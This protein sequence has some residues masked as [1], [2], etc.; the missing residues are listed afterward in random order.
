MNIS[1]ENPE[2][3][4]KNLI[5]LKN[6]LLG[7]QID[8]SQLFQIIMMFH[9]EYLKST[10]NFQGLIESAF[11]DLKAVNDNAEEMAS[12]VSKSSQIIQSN[13]ENSKN[14][15]HSMSEAADSVEKLNSGFKS[16]TDVFNQLNSSIAMIVMKIDEI[17]DISELTNLLALNAAIEAARA[18]E[19]GRG[20]Q[21]VAKEIRK[22]ADR[23]RSNTSGISDILKELNHK[24]NDA[25]GF[26]KDYGKIQSDVL[27][28]IGTTG[29]QLD[30]SANELQ[31]I[32][33]EIGSINE[34]VGN[35]AVRTA[36][37]MESLETIDKTG[38][39]IIEKTPYI[40]SA[41]GNFEKS[42][43]LS[44]QDL[45]DL[46]KIMEESLLNSSSMNNQENAGLRIGHDTAYPPWTHI[47]NGIA[48]GFSVEHVKAILR[49]SGRKALFTGGQWA[50]LYE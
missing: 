3:L 45:T 10:V 16:L 27:G 33:N 9:D 24:L 46:G 42:S 5:L 49:E 28:T 11:G 38:E 26:L 34:L 18:G 22:L 2:Q 17:E 25:N 31:A 6:R 4:L 36:S 13:I 29:E 47:E 1:S 40:D 21:V 37:L 23:S 43:D 44:T 41:V 15:I 32:N 8:S 35:Q 30:H 14:S 20:F 19:K 50:N 7:N 39:S 48:V 12:L